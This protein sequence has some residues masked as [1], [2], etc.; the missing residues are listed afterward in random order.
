MKKIELFVEKMIFA[1][2]WIQLPVYIVLIFTGLVYLFK[3]FSEFF[4]LISNV[5]TFD[6]NQILFTILT[7]ID[8]SLVINLLIMVII[9]G[10]TTFV[11]KIDFKNHEDKP[12]WLD[13]I[14][15]GVIKIKLTMSVIII[16][17][18]D[19]LRS[20]VDI[21]HQ[22]PENLKWQ[23]YIFLIFLL[24]LFV[25]VISEKISHNKGH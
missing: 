5:F 3:F 12:V 25:L 18:I 20:F 17:A 23:I 24:T 14:D 2:R 15:A 13:N 9:G 4:N 8:I 21:N 1:S 10:Y 19:L 11:S 6:G 22:N 7:L 16:A